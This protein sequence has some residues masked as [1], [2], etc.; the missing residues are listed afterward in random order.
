[1]GTCWVSEE[2]EGKQSMNL[3]QRSD[4]VK[5]L[6]TKKGLGAPPQS[7][8]QEKATIQ[9]YYAPKVKE[10]IKEL[11]EYQ[12]ENISDDGVKVQFHAMKLIDDSLR[13]I[14]SPILN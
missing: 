5:K 9:E 11:G 2:K 6:S 3:K 12:Y 4:K 1:M 13:Y 10:K 7:F 8:I 14:K